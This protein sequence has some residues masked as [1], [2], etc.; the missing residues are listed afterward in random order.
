MDRRQKYE[1]CYEKTIEEFE[2]LKDIA[3]DLLKEDVA[4][5]LEKEMEEI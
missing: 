3:T 4:R 2:K 5:Q 1:R